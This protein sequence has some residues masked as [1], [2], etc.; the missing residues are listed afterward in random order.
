[1]KDAIVQDKGHREVAEARRATYLFLSSMFLSEAPQSVFEELARN[2]SSY[3]GVLGEY[4]SKLSQADLGQERVNSAADFARLFLGMSPNPVPPYESVYRSEKR[5]LMQESR[6]EVVAAYAAWGF[7]C[8]SDLRLPEDHAALELEFMAQ[9]CQKELDALEACEAVELGVVAKAQE[10]FLRDHLLAWMPQLC[11]DV[12]ARTKAG[13]Y[14]GL[15]EA[16]KVF[17]SFEAEAFGLEG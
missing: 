8:S 9:L 2:P 4:A 16:A 7:R 14:A 11:D 17:L 10:A 13:L 5:L 3:E 12:L 1:M 6:D 15:A